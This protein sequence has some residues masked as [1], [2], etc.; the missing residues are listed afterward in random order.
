MSKDGLTRLEKANIIN[1]KLKPQQLACGALA[2]VD[3][4][5]LAQPNGIH[6]K[7]KPCKLASEGCPLGSRLE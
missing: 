3:L 7:G 2:Q 5:R 6:P 4:T 1:P